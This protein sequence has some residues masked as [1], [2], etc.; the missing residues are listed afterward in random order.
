MDATDVRVTMDTQEQSNLILLIAAHLN[1]VDLFSADLEFCWE[2]T[3]CTFVNM[4]ISEFAIFGVFFVKNCEN[5]SVSFAFSARLFTH[6]NSITA[7]LM[8]MKT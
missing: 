8:F 6:N 4:Q 3:S 5:A 7:E 1:I 2:F